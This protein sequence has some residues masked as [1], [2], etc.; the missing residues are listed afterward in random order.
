MNYLTRHMQSGLYSLGKLSRSPISSLMTCLIIGIALA[1]PAV[2]F[3]AL[4]NAEFLNN[5]FKNTLEMTL[6]LKQDTTPVQVQSLLKTL[7]NQSQIKQIRAISPNDGLKELQKQAGFDSTLGSLENNPLPWAIVI[8]PNQTMDKPA[9]FENLALHL[10]QL[11]QVD[12][13]QLDILWVKRLASFMTLAH[14]TFYALAIFLSIAVLLIVNNTIRSATEHHHKEI[15]IIKLIG[16]TYAFIRRPF[17]YVGMMYGLLGSI[18]AWLLVVIMLLALKVPSQQLAELYGS[19]FSLIGLG[20]NNLL[21]LFGG[22]IGLGLI[23]SWF[24]VT[25]YLHRT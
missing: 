20:F 4:K 13:V 8:Q 25:K 24:A 1:L 7:K 12:N 23:G 14:R 5:N 15:E 2:L 3:V 9:Q 22:S 18:I 19:Q 21:I 6:Y 10:Q 16:G 17:L 11:P